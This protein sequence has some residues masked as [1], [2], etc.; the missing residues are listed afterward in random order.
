MR[1]EVEGG[2]GGEADEQRLPA[3]LRCASNWRLACLGA[4]HAAAA[5]IRAQAAED[6]IA[7][8]QCRGES[9]QGDREPPARACEPEEKGS[10]DASQKTCKALW[11]EREKFQPHPTFLSFS[12]SLSRFCHPLSLSVSLSPI[13]KCLLYSIFFCRYHQNE[14]SVQG[15]GSEELFTKRFQGQKKK[16][17]NQKKRLLSS[18]FFFS[19]SRLSFFLSPPFLPTP[20]QMVFFFYLSF[21]S[22]SL[23]LFFPN[24]EEK[25]RKKNL[26]FWGWKAEEKTI[27][28][29]F[30]RGPSSWQGRARASSTSSR[31]PCRGR[32]PRRRRRRRRGSRR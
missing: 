2:G 18:L 8:C 4:V 12:L 11:L 5:L 26:N 7:L 3:A 23:S 28:S 19:R 1:G 13:S 9:R 20:H 14:K 30:Q 31:A 10:G 22:L 16:T 6:V 29:T 32:S 27:S 24:E 15:V 25:T 21:L 17:K